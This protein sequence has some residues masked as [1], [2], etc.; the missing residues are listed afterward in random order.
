[1]P[2]SRGT[3]RIDPGKALFEAACALEEVRRVAAR[4]EARELPVPRYGARN[5]LV[6]TGV[7]CDSERLPRVLGARADVVLQEHRIA[8][9]KQEL[10]ADRIV[11]SGLRKPFLGNRDPMDH[12][13][14]DVVSECRQRLGSRRPGSQVG[15]QLLQ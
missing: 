8:E 13:D 4:G 10:C 15:K 5:Q 6:F 14:A 12:L 1:V 3:P 9:R 7:L 11:D 2:V